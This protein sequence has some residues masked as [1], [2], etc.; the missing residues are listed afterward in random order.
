MNRTPPRQAIP[1]TIRLGRPVLLAGVVGLAVALSGYGQTPDE[2]AKH[3]PGQDKGAAAGM[4][5]DGMPKGKDGAAG[6]APDG[7]DAGNDGGME[8]MMDGMMKK[9]G[10]P[11]PKDIY[12]SLM[13]LPELTTEQREE[14]RSQAQ[15]RMRSGVALLSEGLDRLAKA[16]EA[17][18]YAAMQDA[19]AQ[20]REAL[21]RFE[22]GVEIGR[23]SCR[24]RV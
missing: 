3:H 20:V 15:E 24:D 1:A 22:S 6:M 16:T 9:M 10:V 17:E 2:H 8:G 5:P 21:A 14:L 23:A 11:P 19:T 18:D 13:G 4:P 12:P 7:K